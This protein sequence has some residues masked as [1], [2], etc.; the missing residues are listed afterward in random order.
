MIYD[1]TL[2]EFSFYE[3]GAWVNIPTTTVS[4]ITAAAPNLTGGTI[5]STGTIGLNPVLIGLTAIT[6]GNITL[7]NNSIAATNL[8][9][10]LVFTSNGTGTNDFIGT[11]QY[12]HGFTGFQDNVNNI[13]AGTFDYQVLSTDS[14]LLPN[15]TINAVTLVLP[16]NPS[17]GQTYKIIDA[18]GN[19]SSYNV[20]LNGNGELINF[21]LPIVTRTIATGSSPTA[22]AVTPDGTQVY[23]TDH[24]ATSANVTI[25][26]GAST[27]PTVLTTLNAATTPSDVA[28]SADG[29]TAGV[30]NTGSN[31][32][33]FITGVSTAT[34]T[35]LAAGVTVGC[36]RGNVSSAYC[37]YQHVCSCVGD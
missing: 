15:T 20:Y 26:T 13:A 12:Q 30:V 2:N 18:D 8:N 4:S 3:A 11:V 6:V 9:E 1:I 25:L 31:S 23:I 19:A 27:T 29:T 24:G 37:Y 7:Q 16:A 36:Y 34:P 17:T 22:I 35:I 32:V 14:V 28:I 33:T 21:V 5:T 10:S